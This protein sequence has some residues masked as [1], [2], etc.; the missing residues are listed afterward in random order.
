M[1]AWKSPR[2]PVQKIALVGCLI[3]AKRGMLVREEMGRRDI[4]L[5]D[6]RLM[7]WWP[8]NGLDEFRTGCICI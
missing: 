7:V 6:S 2:L 8:T 1:E 5:Q 3:G 4:S